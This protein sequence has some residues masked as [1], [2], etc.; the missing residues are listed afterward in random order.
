[1][2]WTL[3]LGRRVARPLRRSIALVGAV[4]LFAV[5]LNACS[6]L[7]FIRDTQLRIV[8]PR[9][10]STVNLPVT[11]RWVDHGAPARTTLAVFVDEIPIP[12][13]QSVRYLAQQDP[14]CLTTPGCPNRT[15]LL[16]H[17]VH[18]VSK[19]GRSLTLPYLFNNG[20]PNVKDLHRITIVM[21]NHARY[22]ATEASFSVDFFVNRKGP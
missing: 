6:G 14:A 15:W 4:A 13:G 22:R 1:M 8:Y 16:Q 19:G 12:P 10:Y 9:N 18:L 17:G 5:L 3:L 11:I 20:N 21:F 2:S 7:A